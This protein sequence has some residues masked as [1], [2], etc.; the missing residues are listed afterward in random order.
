MMPKPDPL[1]VSSTALGLPPLPPLTRLQRRLLLAAAALS[2]SVGLAAE[3]LLGT[4]ASYLVGN[5]ALAYGVAIGG[6]LAAM[7]LGAYLSQFIAK[8]GHRRQL[9]RAFIQVELWIAPLTAVLPLGL[10]GLFVIDGPL[11]L[12]LFLVTLVLGLLAGLEVPLLT[13]ILEQEQ[14]VGAALAGVLA[15][16]YVGA[17][18]GSLALPVVLLPLLG[19]FPA[20]AIIAALPAFMVGVLGWAFRGSRPWGYMGMAMG[21]ALCLFATVVVPVSD[22]LEDALYKAPIINRI[23]SPYQRIVLTRFGSDLRLFLDGDLQLSTLDEYRYHEA[24]VHPALS[25]HP[26]PRRILLL[27]AGDGMALREVLKWPVEKVVVLELDPA[28]IQLARTHPMLAAVNE[29]AFEDPR[30]DVRT[31]DAFVLAPQLPMR[32][33]VIIADFP[34]PDRGAIAKLYAKGFYQRLLTRLAPQGLFVTQA[35][36]PFFAPKVLD[37][38]TQTLTAVGGVTF[39]YTVTVPS[40]GPWGFVLATQGTALHPEQLALPVSTR[41]LNQATLQNI[42]QLPADIQLGQ[43]KINRLSQP[44][45]VRYQTDPRWAAYE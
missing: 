4:L 34:D 39:P 33:D 28:V 36:S 45:I 10:F 42:F 18:L 40:F 17:L 32:F 5:T 31:G 19:L 16:D 8:D 41:F 37:C 43:A 13:R 9:L 35:S 38:I 25:A 3:L 20:A 24:L 27:G 15:L 6:F 30:V 22:R 26:H 7:G 1:V 44:V 23:Q 12:G 21:V 29:H 11:W 14:G 2:S